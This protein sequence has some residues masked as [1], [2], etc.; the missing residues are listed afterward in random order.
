MFATI[1]TVCSCNYMMFMDHE[2]PP[3]SLCK[4]SAG[5]RIGIAKTQSALR[6]H[7]FTWGQSMPGQTLRISKLTLPFG[8]VTLLV[9]PLMNS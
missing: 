4:A 9:D 8:I 2:S 7:E 1:S 5:L 6:A 3:G